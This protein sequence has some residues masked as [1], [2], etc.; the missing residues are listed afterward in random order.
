MP[1]IIIESNVITGT[2]PDDT[3]GQITGAIDITQPQFDALPDDVINYPHTWN[4]TLGQAEITFVLATYRTRALVLLRDQ[5]LDLYN[6]PFTSTA[7][8]TS[9]TYYLN[10]RFVGLILNSIRADNSLMVLTTDDSATDH[11]ATQLA[12][13]MA[14][15][16]TFVNAIFTRLATA[17]TTVNAATTQQ[18]IDAVTL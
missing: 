1:S 10:G 12:Q 8:G 15:Y 3:Q 6:Q 17:A 14:D 2:S 5:A 16:R 18:A 7:S 13:L 9:R 4:A 11:T